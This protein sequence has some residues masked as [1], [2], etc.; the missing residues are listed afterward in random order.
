MTLSLSPKTIGKYKHLLMINNYIKISYKVTIKIIFIVEYRH[1]IRNC[2]K[3][4]QY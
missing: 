3:G 2:T 1:N 4:S